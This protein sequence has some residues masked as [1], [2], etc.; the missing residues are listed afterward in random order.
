MTPPKPPPFLRERAI[1]LHRAGD[2]AAAEPLYRLL[3]DADG[4]D[5]ELLYLLAVLRFNQGRHPEAVEAARR[6]LRVRPDDAAAHGLTGLAE[7]ARGRLVKAVAA[8]DR[9]LALAPDRWVVLVNR[10]AALVGLGRAAEALACCDRAL[11][12][13]PDAAEAQ[14]NRGDALRDLGRPAEALAAYAAAGARGLA[15]GEARRDAMLAALPPAEAATL[16]AASA[17]ILARSAASAAAL[18]AYERALAL[19]PTVADTLNRHAILLA[20]LGRLDEAVAVLDR[21]I[22]AAPREPALLHNF[23]LFGSFTPGHP[24]LETLAAI[25]AAAL[26]ERRAAFLHFARAKAAA[27]LG[28]TD[29]A[30]AHL[31]TGNALVRSGIA[32]DPEQYE[33]LA[34]RIRTAFVPGPASPRGDDR[35][36]V[37]PVFIVG[38]PRSGS[39]LVERVLGGHPQALAA[40]EID[41]FRPALSDVAPGAYY[42]ELVPDL[43]AADLARLGEAYRARL[44]RVPPGTAVV[45][46]KTLVNAWYVGLIHRALPE[47]RIVHVMRDPVDTGLSCFEQLFNTPQPFAY[48]LGELGRYHGAMATV[49]AHWRMVVPPDVLLDLHYAELVGDPDTQARRL[50]ALCGLAWDPACLD[51]ARRQ[52]R[53]STASIAQVRRPI[54]TASVGRWRAYARHLGPLLD[55]LG[56]DADGRPRSREGAADRA[57]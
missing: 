34:E 52:G 33:R 43:S 26:D 20:E 53:V 14:A 57:D 38:L 23:G 54:S 22:A 32:Y 13:N 56:L 36:S 44:P 10:A 17:D 9:A 7:A 48:D 12:L 31:A 51:G 16:L 49:M 18:D 6:A 11:V 39:T 4:R 41:A 8:Y 25:D 27:D 21:A 1:A 2:L 47:A 5:P 28:D 15:A 29:A 46:D 35:G 3:L 42:P 50:V 19:A 24:H 30:F 45:I 37:R 40:G 55:A